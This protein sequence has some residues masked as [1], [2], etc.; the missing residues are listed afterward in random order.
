MNYEET[1]RENA[2]KITIELDGK[3]DGYIA[4]IAAEIKK[5]G[6]TVEVK[7]HDRD[8]YDYIAK[9]NGESAELNI[10]PEYGSNFSGRLTG[11]LECRVGG[12]G[13]R[14]AYPDGKKGLNVAKIA[15]CMIDQAATQKASNERRLQNN[16]G[17]ETARAMLV[18]I[19]GDKYGMAGSGIT[20]RANNSGSV[21]MDLALYTR[22]EATAAAMLADLK[23]IQ[24]K[25]S[26]R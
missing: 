9:V 12:Y 18:R 21:K 14:R 10:K 22:D 2:R 16:A 15:A 17:Y 23:A 8:G 24:A 1:R 25:Y 13:N 6:A 7:T 19:T 26:N 4:A 3:R 20:T 11:K 5:L